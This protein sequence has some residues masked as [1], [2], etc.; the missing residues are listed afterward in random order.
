MERR[1][2]LGTGILL[3]V[4]TLFN[5]VLGQDTRPESRR[6]FFGGG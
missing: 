3:I 2:Q 4:L 1:R 6:Y 5:A